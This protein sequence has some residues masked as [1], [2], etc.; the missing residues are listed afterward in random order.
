LLAAKY[1]PPAS[2]QTQAK[3]PNSLFIVSVPITFGSTDGEP[4]VG[5]DC[6]AGPKLNLGKLLPFGIWSG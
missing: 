4:F 5:R 1:I 3:T 6:G 2:P